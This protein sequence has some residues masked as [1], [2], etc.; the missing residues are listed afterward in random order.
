MA[1]VENVRNDSFVVEIL[2]KLEEGSQICALQNV[3]D[4]NMALKK[5]DKA[6]I[7]FSAFAPILTM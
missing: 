6:R 4:T 1:E 7:S 5:G 2:A 3:A